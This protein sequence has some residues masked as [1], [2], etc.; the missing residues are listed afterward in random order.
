[1]KPQE[2]DLRVS[3]MDGVIELRGFFGDTSAPFTRSFEW[4]PKGGSKRKPYPNPSALLAHAIS[5]TEA[6]RQVDDP[7]EFLGNC[8]IAWE[9]EMS[10]QLVEMLRCL[11]QVQHI[12]QGISS[13]EEA[14]AL[15]LK[16]ES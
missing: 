7:L 14:E 16:N 11:R 1:M 4:S 5:T 2:M 8:K 10:E 6:Y 12:H 15:Y 13:A 9:A 3:Y